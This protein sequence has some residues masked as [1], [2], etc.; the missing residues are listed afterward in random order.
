MCLA[1]PGAVRK[2]QK[3]RRLRLLHQQPGEA[4]IIRLEPEAAAQKT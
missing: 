1:Q 3:A 4:M 2:A